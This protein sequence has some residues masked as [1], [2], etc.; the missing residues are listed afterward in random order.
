MRA[1]RQLQLI[2][3]A[4]AATAAVS[5][6]ASVSQPETQVSRLTVDAPSPL[7]N[8]DEFRR[9]LLA[10]IAA[11]D[12]LRFVESDGRR[13]APEHFDGGEVDAWVPPVEPAEGYGLLVFILPDDSVM[14]PRDWSAP[15]AE[16]GILAVVVR[17]A[18]N[19]VDLFSRRIPRVLDAY[20]LA[21]SRWRIDPARTWIGGFSGGARVAQRIAMAW[22][23]HFVGTLQLAGSVIVG[24]ARLAPPPP[25]LARHLQERTR[26]VF[27]SGLQDT[28]NRGNDTFARESM[29]ALCFADVVLRSPA[30][31][32]HWVPGGHELAKAL[33]ALE[34]PLAVDAGCRERLGREI[35]AALAA[36]EARFAAGDIVA[37]RAGL[38]AIDDRYGGLAAPASVELARR[39][40]PSMTPS[41]P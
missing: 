41:S 5:V 40:L 19:E 39:M 3:V 20:S 21:T 31:L 12:L 1:I 32:D 27:V 30:R 10:P 34:S 16:R 26:F 38:V 8:G 37:A 2:L 15:L 14:L 36:V 9:R 25:E 33:D 24:T 6:P 35:A 28:R 17:G 11:D 7:V 18:G 29:Q 4:L 22:P 23:E 13:L